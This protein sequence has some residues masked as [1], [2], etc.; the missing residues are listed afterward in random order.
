MQSS[1]EHASAVLTN[2]RHPG[3]LF[4]ELVTFFLSVVSRL[5]VVLPDSLSPRFCRPVPWRDW[6][7]VRF[8]VYFFFIRIVVT[9]SSNSRVAM[10]WAIR[11]KTVKTQT[12]TRRGK[13]GSSGPQLR[14]KRVPP[15]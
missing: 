12:W 1:D 3:S 7:S 14:D 2:I 13:H 8:D 15:A 5:P 4:P 10:T 9:N 6:R 11:K